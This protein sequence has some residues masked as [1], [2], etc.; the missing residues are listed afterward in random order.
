M[1]GYGYSIKNIILGGGVAPLDP[2]AVA[3]LTAA[4]ITDPTITSA[5]DTLVVD[6]KDYGI[7]SKMK[8]LYP[9]VGGTASTH[10]VD[11]I[12]LNSGTFNGGF[13]HDAN[14]I[15]GNGSNAYFNTGKN[16]NAILNKDSNSIGYY[17]RTSNP[18]NDRYSG[19]GTPN[20]FIL[21]KAT[22]PDQGT[23]YWG[24]S[25]ASLFDNSTN[26]NRFIIGNRTSSTAVAIYRNGALTLS[27]SITSQNIPTNN[28]YISAVNN[29]GTPFLYSNMNYAFWYF[30]DGLTPTE[31][32]DL[33]TVVL[34]FQTAL[35][36]QV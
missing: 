21:G 3:F 10:A 7:W 12:T 31:V 30:S 23:D 15:T 26:V 25:S 36:R 8:A 35:S 29:G 34:A 5:I 20:W 16:M 32:A 2:D 17:N 28:F 24:N 1:Y 18:L 14:G 19:V 9:F 22:S 27:G 33:T 6:L 11:L 4:G 13:T